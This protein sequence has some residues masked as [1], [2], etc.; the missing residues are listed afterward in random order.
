MEPIQVAPGVA[1]PPDG[2]AVR[3]VRSSGPGGQNVNKV[4]SKVQL[5]VD[6]ERIVGL[7]EDARARLLRATRLRRDAK[8]WLLV[9]AQRSR[10]QHR[11][12]EDARRRVQALIAGCLVAGRPRR[13]T[14][15]SA[16]ARER[17][18]SAKKRL[19][20]R[21]RARRPRDGDPSD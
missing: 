1:V 21:K 12:L 19:A 4:A 9:V 10:D 2:L 3:F 7:T 14:A 17:R 16:S 11:N 18:L 6:L 15:P 13:P 8:G 5:R 20:A